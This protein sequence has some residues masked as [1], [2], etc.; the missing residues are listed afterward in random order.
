MM[1]MRYVGKDLHNNYLQNAVVDQ[2]G[3]LIKNGK[4]END[5]HKIGKCFVHL[6]DIEIKIQNIQIK[7]V[8]DHFCA[9]Y[10]IYECLTEEKNPDVKLS[11]A[12]KTICYEIHTI[13]N[14]KLTEG[15][16]DKYI[17]LL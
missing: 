14:N 3:N 2:K 15:F 8:I 6:I 10:E 1:L 12:I 11:N 17:L 7:I 13:C 9:W 16:F 4:I 5:I